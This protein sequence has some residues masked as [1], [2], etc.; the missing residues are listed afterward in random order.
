[1]LL[2]LNTLDNLLWR[3]INKLGAIEESITEYRG[4]SVW[5]KMKDE[6]YPNVKH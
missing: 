2:A 6:N 4:P 3:C 1:M 5:E